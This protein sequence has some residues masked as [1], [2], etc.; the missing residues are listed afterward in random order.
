M[1]QHGVVSRQQAARLGFTPSAV[2]RAVRSRRLEWLSR[3]VLRFAGSPETPQQRVM[4]AV[5]DTSGGAAALSTSLAL[6]AV[7]GWT[8]DPVHVLTDRRPHRGTDHLGVVHSS[9]R[10]SP[11]DLTVIDGIPVTTAART[12]LDLSIRLR[13]GKVEDLCDDL[14]RR[15]LLTVEALHRLAAELPSGRGPSGWALLRRLAAERPEGYVPTGSKLERRFERIL[16]EAGDPPFERQ[17]DLGDDRGWI[18][19]VDFADRTLK[20]VVEVQSETF[21]STLSDRRRDAERIARL[22]AAGWIVVE[23]H[24]REIFS[25]P[26]VVLAKVRAA[27]AHARR[28]AA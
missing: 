15:R 26:E 13:S 18:G 21:H 7:P 9:I 11:D 2:S 23:I 27:R 14:L 20:V 10:L 22:R 6:R 8:L 4:A 17:V 19:R 25:A 16:E 28:I 1:R 12:L 24:E 3:R 5:L